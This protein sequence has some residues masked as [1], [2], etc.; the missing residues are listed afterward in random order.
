M[1]LQNFY[2]Y[3]QGPTVHFYTKND[4]LNDAR[5]LRDVDKRVDLGFEPSIS[6]Q[7][8]M[9]LL[10]EIFPGWGD[11]GHCDMKLS[12][13]GY[14]IH[15]LE[16]V[17]KFINR[18]KEF[19][20]VGGYEDLLEHIGYSTEDVFFLSCNYCGHCVLKAQSHGILLPVNKNMVDAT[21]KNV[22]GLYEELLFGTSNVG[23]TERN[24]NNGRKV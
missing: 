19:L 3:P 7:E 11:I 6:D 13:G 23:Q 17:R 15:K 5:Y 12:G 21:G 1:L 2:P 16:R 24:V 18:Y 8:A 10:Q 14:C 4:L 9:K 22:N 20:T